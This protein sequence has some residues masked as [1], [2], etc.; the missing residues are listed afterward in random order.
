MTKPRALSPPQTAPNKRCSAFLVP[1]PATFFFVS[2]GGAVLRFSLRVSTSLVLPS[3]FANPRRPSRQ[4]PAAVCAGWLQ[5]SSRIHLCLLNSGAFP[6]HWRVGSGPTSNRF[7]KIGPHRRL[8]GRIGEISAP[9][10]SEEMPTLSSNCH[11]ATHL[12]SNYQF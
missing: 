1:C 7:R 4:S 3:L 10:G 9:S 5:A 11:L 12:L 2:V 8:T 6:A